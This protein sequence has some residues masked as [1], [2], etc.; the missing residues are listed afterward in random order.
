MKTDNRPVYRFDCPDGTINLEE[1]YKYDIQHW[2][3]PNSETFTEEEANKEI[4]SSI[5]EVIDGKFLGPYSLGMVKDLLDFYKS[6]NVKFNVAYKKKKLREV[7]EVNGYLEGTKMDEFNGLIFSNN[8]G[9]ERITIADQ[10]LTGFEEYYSIRLSRFQKF[11][12]K[13]KHPRIYI[14]EDKHD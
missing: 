14:Y 6:V 3:I 7:L 5:D 11:I 12:F 1:K 4:K 2:Q 8:K 13:L 10:E 9:K